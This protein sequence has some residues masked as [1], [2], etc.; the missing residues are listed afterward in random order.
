[1][2][3]ALCRHAATETS[4]PASSLGREGAMVTRILKFYA[5]VLPKPSALGLSRCPYKRLQMGALR[6]TYSIGCVRR[7][8]QGKVSRAQLFSSRLQQSP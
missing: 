6:A 1:M 7:T 2:R 4:R 8:L 3:T 5:L